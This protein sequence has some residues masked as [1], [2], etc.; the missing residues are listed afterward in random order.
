MILKHSTVKSP[1]AKARNTRKAN[2]ALYPG[3]APPAL[4]LFWLLCPP[5]FARN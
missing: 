2:Q 4:P 5:Q 3:S 1:N